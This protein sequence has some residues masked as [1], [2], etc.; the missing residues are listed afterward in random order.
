MQL[1][2][3]TLYQI[4][5]KYWYKLLTHLILTPVLHLILYIFCYSTTT[6]II[7]TLKSYLYSMASI[8]ITNS[9]QTQHASN[10][11]HKYCLPLLYGCITMYDDNTQSNSFLNIKPLWDTA[12]NTTLRATTLQIMTYGNIYTWGFWIYIYFGKWL[13]TSTH[14][15]S[16]QRVTRPSTSGK[17]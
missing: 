4:M 12:E 17:T 1:H 8:Y 3:H 14:F 11:T 16:K 9:P 13:Y 2:A 10:K 7:T 6:R 5:S 15:I